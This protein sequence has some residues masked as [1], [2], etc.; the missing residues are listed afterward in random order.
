MSNIALK[1]F[2]SNEPMPLNRK[3]DR[4][5]I[6]V[7]FGV[8]ITHP[9]CLI[10]SVNGKVGD[11]VLNAADVGADPGSALPV[12]HAHC[13]TRRESNGP[14]FPGVTRCMAHP[15]DLERTGNRARYRQSG[16]YCHFGGKT[17]A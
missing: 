2:W 17:S 15:G 11:V 13:A 7:P 9:T 3:I 1:V 5:A 6:N 14:E 12:T 4:A 16:V 10:K 8:L